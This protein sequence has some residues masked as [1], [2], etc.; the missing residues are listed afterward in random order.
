MLALLFTVAEERYAVDAS[1]IRQVLPLLKLRSVPES[2]P[3]IAGVAIYQNAPIAILDASLLLTNQ[4]TPDLL[5]SRLVIIDGNGPLQGT[6][7]G[8]LLEQATST[9]EMDL[10]RRCPPPA[11]AANSPL[12]DYLSDAD[13]LIQLIEPEKIFDAVTL[14][15][16]AGAG[17]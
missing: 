13:G 8:L 1:R 11:S 9:Q 6:T 12:G 5:S 14:Q 17:Q 3:G 16:I 10:S 2:S 7:Y 4:A 15:A